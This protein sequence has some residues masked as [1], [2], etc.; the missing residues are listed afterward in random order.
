[1]II[2]SNKK[3]TIKECLIDYNFSR[4]TIRGLDF[5]YINNKEY[6]LWQEVEKDTLIDVPIKKEEFL[7]II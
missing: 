2:K 1:M 4:K 7:G 5:V 3:Q 6:R